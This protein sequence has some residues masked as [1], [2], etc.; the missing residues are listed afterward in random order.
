ML[1]RRSLLAGSLVSSSLY[2][3]LSASVL[4]PAL[5]LGA[6]TVA[7]D[8]DHADAE[9]PMAMPLKTR[10]RMAWVF[11]SGGPRGFVHVGVLKGLHE[12]GLKPDLLVGASVGSLVAVMYASGRPVPEIVETALDLQLTGLGRLAVGGDARFSGAGI[13][14]LV[15]REINDTMLQDL[16]I[17]AVCVAVRR[18]DGQIV[19]FNTGDAGL[20]VQASSAIEGQFTPV[21]IRGEQYV[22]PDLYLPLPVRLARQLGARKVLS[23]DASAHEDKAPEGAQRFRTSDLKKRT[24]TAPDALAA[25]INLHPDFGYFVNLSRDFRERAINAGYRA[26]LAAASNLIALHART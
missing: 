18:K 12:L 14:S 16:R 6:C 1:Q 17:P 26:T 22:D 10:P 25:D 23:V 8:A 15:R 4:A 13:A 21:R 2:G 5:L 20:A 24:L 7:P 19:G 11:S 9:A 3:S